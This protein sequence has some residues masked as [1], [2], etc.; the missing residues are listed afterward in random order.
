MSGKYCHKLR[1][2]YLCNYVA[3]N[4]NVNRPDYFHQTERQVRLG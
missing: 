3:F 4:N 2:E 1:K